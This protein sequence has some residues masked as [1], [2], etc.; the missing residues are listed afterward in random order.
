[1]TED[2]RI[3]NETWPLIRETY[4]RYKPIVER[5]GYMPYVQAKDL[6]GQMQ[7]WLAL[8]HMDECHD[9]RVESLAEGQ[10]MLNWARNRR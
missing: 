3:I 6:K 4:N 7:F 9:A 5:L 10:V 8:K 2:E 1:M